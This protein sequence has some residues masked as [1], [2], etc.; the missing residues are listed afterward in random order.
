MPNV[1][2]QQLLMAGT[3]FGHLTRRW[4]PKMSKYIFDS[5]HG[6]HII[7]LKK[8]QVC[9]DKA[10]KALQD[11]VKVGEKV[12]FVGTKKQAK[13]IIRSEANR[14]NMPFVCE[15]WLGGMLTNFSTIRKSLKN[16]QS[17]ER[18]STDGTFEKL[19]KKERLTIDKEKAKLEKALGGIRDLK[20]LPGAVFIVDIK[21]EHIAVAEARKL[22]IPIVA[23]V[24]TNVNPEIVDYPIPGNDDAFKSV[25]LITRSLADAVME[26]AAVAAEM[27][28]TEQAITTGIKERPPQDKQGS[29]RR[30]RRRPKTDTPP[31]AAAAF[32]E[33]KVASEKGEP[34]ADS[35]KTAAPEKAAA[36]SDDKPEPVKP[37]E[38]VKK[39]E[40]T[41]SKVKDTK[42]ET[43]KDHE[44]AG[45]S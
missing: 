20:K 40:K 39:I 38:D 31:V 42:E 30:P 11:I 13:D 22:S 9:I 12:L 41:E 43:K 17:L 32:R 34:P 36:K 5:K 6:I 18:I 25:G 37:T 24:D 16:L 26:A 15:R 33:A 2:I 23:V 19:S 28:V 44:E 14:I 10:C 29:R 45:A 8:T 1:S 21:K 7:D 35:T 27:R 4:N 3:H